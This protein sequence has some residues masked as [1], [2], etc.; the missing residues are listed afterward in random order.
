MRF[1]GVCLITD[2]VPA[3]ADFYTEVLGVEADGDETH[4]ELRT[5]GQSVTIFSTEGMEGLAPGCMRSAG[6]GCFTIGFGVDDVDR[7]H[8]RLAVLGIEV[9]MPPTTHPWGCR[10][11]WFRDLD[12]NIVDFWAM[13]GA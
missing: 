6:H 3:L 12:G 2:N 4:V 5:E 1:S 10:S 11:F 9:I 13:P 8:E 7:E